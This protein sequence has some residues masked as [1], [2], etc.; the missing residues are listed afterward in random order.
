[1]QTELNVSRTALYNKLNGIET[2]V[3]SALV[4]QT[5][6]ELKDVIEEMGGE[7]EE[8]LPGYTVKMIDGNCIEASEHRIEELRTISAGALPGKSLVVYEPSVGIVTNVFPCED[9]HKQERALLPA[10]IES[11]K[12]NDLWIADRNFCIRSF[13]FGISSQERNGFFVIRQHKGLPYAEISSFK[14]KGKSVDG[15]TS[16]QLVRI[17]S[18]SGEE[19]IIRRIKSV[20]SKSNRDGDKEVYIL[21]NLPKDVS[22]KTIVM[23]YR[24]RW[25]IET[26]FQHLEKNLNSEVNTLGYPK[27][28]LFA[29]CTALISY[30]VMETIMASFR[31]A[32]GNDVDEK[33]SN[34][35]FSEE[36]SSISLGMNIA[37]RQEEW[38]EISNLSIEYFSKMIVQIAKGARLGKYKKHYRGVK[39]PVQKDKYD[40]KHPHVSTFKILSERSKK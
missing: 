33:V 7:R 19:F 6:V 36:I 39:H 11:V 35:Y 21:S 8:L 22:A 15:E 13:L 2:T 4:R 17:T 3:S 40:P 38:D 20:I 34:Y 32:H 24:K 27:A 29:F 25:N 28:A 31:S 18:D 23:L 5:A 14:R 10:V 16:E 37:I 1:M 9:G 30:N 26:A 12:K